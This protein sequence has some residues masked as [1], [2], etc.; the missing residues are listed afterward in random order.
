MK[1]IYSFIALIAAVALFTA[2]GSDD[3]S[4][5]ATPTLDIESADVLFEAEGG[6]GYITANTTSELTATTE[7]NW[8]TLTVTGNVVTVTADPNITLDGRSAVIKLSAGGTEATIT[9]TQKASIYGVQSLE[10]EI[11]D[12]EASLE[13]PV[14]HTMPVTVESNAEWITAVFNEETNEIEI[15]AENND[16]ADPREGTITISMG[17][18][19]DE[20]TITQIGFLLNVKEEQVVSKKNAALDGYAVDVE[21]SRTVSVTTDDDW[22]VASF[23]TDNDQVVINAAANEEGGAARIG[24]VTVTSGPVTKVI[25]VI[26]YDFITELNNLFLLNYYPSP[27]ATTKR[28]AIS[29]FNVG[30]DPTKSTFMFMDNANNLFSL[31]AIIDEEKETIAI[32]PSSSKAGTVTYQEQE[33]GVY[34]IFYNTSGYWTGYNNTT[35]MAT[36]ELVVEENEDG[37]PAVFVDLGGTFGRYDIEAWWMRMFKPDAFASANDAKLNWLLF[38]FPYLEQYVVDE[39]SGAKQAFID[40]IK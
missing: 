18:Y 6:D 37:T 10:Y 38:Y 21:H 40:A 1:R 8:V 13:I 9:A 11:G 36:G 26:Q 20:I 3:A 27:T 23:D 29:M 16:E 39:G 14:V 28:Y 19:S 32:G 22:I 2:C 17:D 31:P 15:V 35:A 7:S 34:L 4:Y 33:Y 30:N 12:Y 24:H 5:N 25:S